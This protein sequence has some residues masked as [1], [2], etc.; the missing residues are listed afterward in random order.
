MR[1]TVV[2]DSRFDKRALLA[3]DDRQFSAL[4]G[5]V[6]VW[7]EEKEVPIVNT[8]AKMG[9]ESM[10]ENRALGSKL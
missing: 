1:P 4:M 3:A 6:D 5:E 7:L 2:L 8:F 9:G 10:N